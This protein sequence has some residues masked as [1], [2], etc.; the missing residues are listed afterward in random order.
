MVGVIVCMCRTGA[1]LLA[2]Y[3]LAISA[4]PT[5]AQTSAPPSAEAGDM[6]DPLVDASANLE[7]GLGLALRQ[8][9]SG[10]LLEAMAT[11]ERLLLSYPE[12][13]D[14]MIMHAGLLC[15]LDDVVGGK[16][17]LAV[18]TQRGIDAA[19]L[20]GAQ[21]SCETADSVVAEGAM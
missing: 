13:A 2:L 18:L 19:S 12:S 5:M 10:L 14:A 6:L 15:R 8:Q 20:A 7:S 9:Q 4:P 1:M 3:G 11:L 17:E 16:A 21:S